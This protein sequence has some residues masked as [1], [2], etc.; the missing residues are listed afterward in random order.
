[1]R[2]SRAG[3]GRVV[4]N[5]VVER[6]WRRVTYAAV[7]RQEDRRVPEALHGVQGYGAFD[8]RERSHQALTSHTPA[9]VYR[10]GPKRAA[11]TTCN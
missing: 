9:A 10:Q 5:L 11:V 8:T 7:S 2:I 4:E 6:L 3:R 1:V